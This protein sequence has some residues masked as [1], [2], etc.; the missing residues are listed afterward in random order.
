VRAL[1]TTLADNGVDLQG[2]IDVQPSP[3]V[4]PTPVCQAPIVSA[5]V[6]PCGRCK[7][8]KGVT[9]CRKCGISVQP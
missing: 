4:C 6:G 8:R 9:T 3:A 2:T 7:T 1:F 5:T